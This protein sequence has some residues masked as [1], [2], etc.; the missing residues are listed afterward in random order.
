M[1]EVMSVLQTTMAFYRSFPII[2][3]DSFHQNW[4][5]DILVHAG[6]LRTLS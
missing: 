3:L 2:P 6:M 1:G 5:H 4:S